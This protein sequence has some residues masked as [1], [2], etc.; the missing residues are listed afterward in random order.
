MLDWP[1]GPWLVGAAGAV[2]VG[3]ALYQGYKGLRQRFLDDS[4]TEQMARGGQRAY[5]R[6][7]AIVGHCAR[8]V[9]FGLVGYFLIKA[10]IEYAAARRSASTARWRS[11]RTSRTGRRCSASS[12][13]A[14]SR[15]R[16]TRSRTR[17]TGRSS[18]VRSPSDSRSASAPARGGGAVIGQ[19]DSTRSAGIMTGVCAGSAGRARSNPEGGGWAECAPPPRPGNASR[20]SST[21]RKRCLRSQMRCGKRALTCT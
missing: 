11:W 19:V 21:E 12:R 13:R 7:S 2:L 16:S 18:R 5:H 14:W 8:M 3:V 17:A 9:V 20:C 10:A 6:G 15:S 4:K 1:A